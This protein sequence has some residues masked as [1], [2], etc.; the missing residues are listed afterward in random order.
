VNFSV[1][2]TA[3]F[4]TDYTQTGAAT[5]NT[6]TGTVTFGAGNSTTTV[7][8]DPSADSTVE[9]DETVVLTLTSGTGYNVVAPV[10]ATGTITNDDTDVSVAVSP[11]SVLEDGASN[12]VYTFTRVGVTSSPLTVNFSV[13]GTAAFAADYTQTG[14][15]TFNT[16]T[17]TVV[18]GAGNTT[19]TVTAD[20]STDSTYEND[21]T[22]ILTLTSGTGY[23][24]SS[25]S[26]ATGTIENDDAAPTLSINDVSQFEGNSGTTSYVFTVTKTGATAVTASV[27][28]ATADGSAIQPGDYTSNSGTLTFLAAETTKDITVLVKGD[29]VYETNETFGVNL[30]APSQ[31]TLADG[32][33]T[34]TIQNDDAAPTLSIDDVTHSEGNS[35]TTS[36]VFTV[37]KTGATAV[38]ASVN[39]ATADGTATQPS[40]YTS[41]SGPL[42]FLPADVSKQITV[43]VTGDIN[44][45]PNETFTVNLTSPTDATITDGSGLGTITNDDFFTFLGFFTP[46][47]N[48]PAVNIVN[49]GRAIPLKWQLHTPAGANVQDLSVVQDIRFVQVACQAEVITNPIDGL[50]DDAGLS[51]LRLVDGGY[52]FNWKTEKRFAN[53][54]MEIRVTLTDGSP[55]QLAKFRFT[56]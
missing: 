3:D 19:T 43:L 55:A 1:G 2:G 21:E 16:T 17:G 40:D 31:A 32:S 48:P 49:A 38:N 7:T 56:K 34:G 37:S 14:A 44:I 50:A 9:P 33:G 18:F 52:Q 53:T 42:T 10:T 5:F 20:P 4:A 30:S 12:L 54:C 41:N 35:G 39:F 36:Y 25:P 8:A 45:E 28:F 11:A 26:A 22:V 29:T 27:S 6:T 23:N 15:A 24:V 51:D 46:V 47:E 13:G